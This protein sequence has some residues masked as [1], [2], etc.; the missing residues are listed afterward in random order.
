MNLFNFCSKHEKLF[1]CP[2]LIK[3]NRTLGNNG[4]GTVS[5]YQ[6]LKLIKFIHLENNKENGVFLYRTKRERQQIKFFL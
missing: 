6:T 4:P 2:I 1:Y 5:F 3:L